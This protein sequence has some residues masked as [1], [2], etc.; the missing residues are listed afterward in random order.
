L[1]AGELR[2]RFSHWAAFSAAAGPDVTLAARRGIFVRSRLPMAGRS[3]RAADSASRCRS[4]SL[5]QL[6]PS[7]VWQNMGRSLLRT[8]PAVLDPLRPSAVRASTE[9]AWPLTPYVARRRLRR[10]SFLLLP[11]LGLPRT[12]PCGKTRDWPP[13]RQSEPLWML[14]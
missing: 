4:F 11:S 5:R 7:L 10:S 3:V 6:Q 1:P 12:S 8:S 9:T 13:P 2:S 14:V